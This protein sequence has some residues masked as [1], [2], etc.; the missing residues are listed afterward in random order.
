MNAT[1]LAQ[2]LSMLPPWQAVLIQGDTGVGKSAIVRQLA[3]SLKLPLVDVRASTLTEGDMGYPNLDKMRELDMTVFTLPSWYVRACR[4]PV[5]LFLD[6]W[7]RG[8]I[9]VL[10]GMMQITL[11]R[12]F[13]NDQ[14]GDPVSLHPGTRI[15]A[16]VNIGHEFQV[17]AMDRA[18]L[19]RFWMAQLTPDATSWIQ[20]ATTEGEVDSLIVDFIRENDRFLQNAQ[21]GDG[22]QQEP[23]PRSWDLFNK[24]LKYRNFSLADSRGVLPDWFY[25]FAVG[26]IGAPTAQALIG[27]VKEYK[28]QLTA[29]DILTRFDRTEIR[30]AAQALSTEGRMALSERVVKYAG[31]NDISSTD[32]LD[33][34]QGYFNLLTGEEQMFL[35]HLFQS[36]REDSYLA[37]MS[38]ATTKIVELA[39]RGRNVE[40][41]S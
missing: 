36:I 38:R 9:G 10:N 22:T 12:Q 16:A 24:A 15:V 26:F 11:D 4:E 21:P 34:L 32:M 2:I 25:P 23:T 3:A 29:L 37:F 18:H 5:L 19:N 31:E 41:K 13:G 39:S 35:F 33:N 28:Y 1:E 8:V 27:Y 6:E 40:L 7:N 14:N 17:T 30:A 20:W